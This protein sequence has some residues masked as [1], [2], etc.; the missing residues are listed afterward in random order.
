MHLARGRR[1]VFLS[2]AA[3]PKCSGT[4]RW[5]PDVGPSDDWPP[6][7]VCGAPLVLREGEYGRFLGC[8]R[9][10]TCTGRRG[11]LG[12]S[13]LQDFVEWW[14]ARLA[15][16]QGPD[17]PWPVTAK[18]YAAAERLLKRYPIQ[19]LKR[20]ARFFLRTFTEPYTIS[21]FSRRIKDVTRRRGG[22][23]RDL[24]AEVDAGEPLA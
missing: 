13:Y 23:Q 24:T 1:G 16:I 20:F 12:K 14:A 8:S 3:Y 18:D 11:T 17:H 19:R 5:A 22:E 21:S 2:C 9:Y 4:R 10:P 7:S 15:V 6:C